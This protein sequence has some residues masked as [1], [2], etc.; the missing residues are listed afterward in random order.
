MEEAQRLSSDDF[1]QMLPEETMEILDA[2]RT[3]NNGKPPAFIRSLDSKVELANIWKERP[4][5]TIL[6]AE[7]K[8]WFLNRLNSSTAVWKIWGNTT[9][10]LDMRADPQNLPQDM[11]KPWPWNG[12]AG[13]GGGDHSTAY[14]ERGE[15]YDFVSRKGI[16]GFATVA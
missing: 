4:A 5:Q 8:T 10:T 14:T 6:G 11:T 9:A 13:F 2:G 15:I 16:T 7:Q 3:Y 1:P 12:Y